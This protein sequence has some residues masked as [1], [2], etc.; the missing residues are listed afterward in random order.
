MPDNCGLFHPAS[1]TQRAPYEG[2]HTPPWRRPYVTGFGRC[3]VAGFPAYSSDTRDRTKEPLSRRETADGL[4]FVI[5][6]VENGIKLGNLQ[7]VMNLLGQVEQLQLST[8]V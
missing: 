8:L 2:D 5:V 3:G 4:G 6:D 7:Q 1:K